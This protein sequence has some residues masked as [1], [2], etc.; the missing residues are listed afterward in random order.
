LMR[1]MDADRGK[2]LASL[3]ELEQLDRLVNV[4]RRTDGGRATHPESCL[5]SS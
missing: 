4:M 3:A 5:S 2:N 1:R